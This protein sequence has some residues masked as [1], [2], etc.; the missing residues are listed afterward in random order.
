MSLSKYQN[1]KKSKSLCSLQND[2]N[3]ERLRVHRTSESSVELYVMMSDSDDAVEEGKEDSGFEEKVING[4]I[5]SC[6]EQKIDRL[7]G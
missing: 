2:G 5:L 6:L 3:N 4:E 7:S 1:L